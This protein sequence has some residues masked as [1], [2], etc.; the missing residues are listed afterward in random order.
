[1]ALLPSC[2]EPTEAAAPPPPAP[3]SGELAFPGA[4]GHGATSRGGR[5]GRILYVD[6]LTDRGPGTLRRCIEEEGPRVCVFR[7]SGIIRFEGASP[8]IKNPYLTI[9]GQTAP[10]IGITI[11]NSADGAGRTP[12]IVK[13]THDVVIRHVRVRLDTFGPDPAGED[14]FTIENSRNVILDHVSGSWARDELV[15]PYGDNDRVTI[16]WSIFAEG[17]PPH[18]KCALLGSDPDGPQNVSFIGNLCAH[19]GDRN[20]DINFEPRSCVEV[21]NNVFY[22]ANSQFAEV[23][24]SYGGTPVAIAGNY[25]RGG[26]NTAR[27]AVGIDREIIGAKGLSRIYLW[28]NRFD[29]KFVHTSPLLAPATVAQPPCPMTIVPL[30]PDQAYGRVLAGAGAFPR[31]DIDRRVIEDVRTRRGRIKTA[32]GSIPPTSDATAPYPDQDR[33]GMADDWERQMRTDPQRPD[34]WGDAD[35]D[36]DYNLDEFLDHLHRRLTAAPPSS[37]RPSL[38]GDS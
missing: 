19:S 7:V 20:P 10:G 31:D 9:A 13:G 5:G 4:I 14:A 33:D 37:A 21:I 18:D 25:F 15:N 22:N 11:A 30:T 12:I 27:H 36:G 34:A 23:W 28:D 24:E 32:P 26:P 29:G 2:S 1:M 17:I 6:S 3:V 8:A 16:S 35:E 38:Q